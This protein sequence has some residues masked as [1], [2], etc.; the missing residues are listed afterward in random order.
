MLRPN[1][2]QHAKT[3]QRNKEQR[4]KDSQSKSKSEIDR[5]D[6]PKYAIED[7]H[8]HF[9]DGVS[10]KGEQSGPKEG[11]KGAPDRAQ[12]QEDQEDHYEDDHEY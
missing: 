8:L 10:E 5:T 1:K 7:N 12:E 11:E 4:Y 2:I 6:S 9:E 3:N